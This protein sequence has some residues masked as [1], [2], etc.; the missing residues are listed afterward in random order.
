MPGVDLP[1]A[2]TRKLRVALHV[3]LTDSDGRTVNLQEN[4]AITVDLDA[5]AFAEIEG[6]RA[7]HGQSTFTT[8]L[9]RD[10][11]ARAGR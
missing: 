6:P 9:Q 7:V 1:N 3:L 4:M 10:E 8:C 5:P 11:T 2:G